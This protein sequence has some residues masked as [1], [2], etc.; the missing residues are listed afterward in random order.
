MKIRV[1]SKIFYGFMSLLSANII[2]F[3]LF[4]F[5]MKDIETNIAISFILGGILG[6]IADDKLN[7]M[8]YDPYDNYDAL[9][10]VFILLLV[11]LFIAQGVFFL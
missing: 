5:G 10:F 4:L 2:I 3:F 9:F 1:L 6:Y 7:V 11:G 8:E